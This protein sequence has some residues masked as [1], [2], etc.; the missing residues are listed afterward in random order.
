M[1]KI[2]I[3]VGGTNTD[4][5]LLDY[6]SQLIYS[7]KSPTSLDIKSGIEQSLQQLLQG[8]NI[9][10]TKITH[11]MLGTTQCTNAIVERK[12]LARVGVIRLGYPATASVLPYTA[13]PS[14]MIDKL[15]GN[16]AIAHGGYEYD[17]QLLSALNHA[18]ITKLLE[19][20]RDQ[21]E[22]IA[23]VGVFSSIKNDQELQVRDWIRAIYGED[24]PVSCS[25]LI[26]SVGLIER[27][28]ATILNAALC[29]VIETTTQGFIQ[30][31][32]AEGIFNVD[33]YLCQNDG[34]LMSIDY[35]K[36]FPILTI[37]CGPTNSIRGAS[38]LSQIQNTMVLDVG[39]TTSDIGVLQD[40]FPRESSVAVEVGDIRTNF[41]MPD[42]ISVGLG[43]GSIVRVKENKITVGP[44]SVGYKISE[45]ALVFGGSTMTT[46][47]IAVRLGLA[48]VGDRNLVA[49]I[50]EAFAK[51]VQ[52]EISSLL[53]QAIDKMK[54]SS[55]DVS[56]VL[57]GGGSIIVPEKIQGVSTIVKSEFGGVAN[58]IGAS[59]AQISGQYEQI[60]IYSKEP[61]EESLEDAQNKAVKQAVL[62][63]ALAETIELVEVEETPLAY[64]PENATRLKVKVVGKMV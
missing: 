7:V 14:D 35:A 49:H 61:R 32:Q 40:G 18:E 23:I 39:G 42:I 8:A 3:D 13:W 54:T 21:V 2:G 57:V 55:E 30:A 24:F 9:D 10:K 41:R 12:K 11:A 58:A 22:S 64:H 37:A 28:N 33:V 38:Y 62:A 25:S 52:E 47:D 44:D 17:G 1:Y 45:E 16:Y 29:K 60:Y 6:N 31:L 26:G 15:S 4:A 36:Q 48:E 63:G 51:A 50:D 43:G 19:E 46:T 53:E 20:W 34:T 27:E 59:I 56:L 5:I